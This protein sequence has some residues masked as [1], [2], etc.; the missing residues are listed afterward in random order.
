MALASRCSLV[1]ICAVVFASTPAIAQ[2]G[3]SRVG[4]QPAGQITGQVRFADT[5]EPAFNVMVSCDGTQGGFV[6]QMQ[7]DRNGRFNFTGLGPAQFI[8]R[9]RAPGYLE[10][11]QTVELATTSNANL[12]INLQVDPSTSHGADSSP[13]GGVVDARIPLEAQKEYE[14]GRAALIDARKQNVSEGVRHLE[15]AVK[16]YPD[17]LEAQILLGTGYMDLKQWAKAEATLRRALEINSQA[18]TALLALGQVYLQQKKYD[19]AEKVLLQDIGLD[20]KS[21][22]A[23]LTL[24]RVYWEKVT[25]TQDEAQWRPSLEKAYQEV[26]LALELDPNLADAH[27]LKG[28]LY[29]KVRRAQDALNEFEE[30]L[31]LDPKGHFAEQTRALADKIKKALA[32]QKP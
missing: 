26:K 9:V 4:A 20:S 25:G 5:R 3:S 29:F 11:Q 18:T 15:K 17:Y 16:V 23:H 10:E 6:G 21:A 19:E 7:T 24:A 31:R 22:L 27:L 13:A 28:N 1:V 30:Y 12:Q 2:M 14:A 32:D 8:I